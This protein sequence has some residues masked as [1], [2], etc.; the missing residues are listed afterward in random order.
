MEGDE[1]KCV[2][3]WKSVG[4]GKGRCGGG[5]GNVEG[6]GEK[7][8]EDPT[9]PTSPLTSPTLQH[10]SPNLSPHLFSHLPPHFSTPTPPLPHSFHIPPI[11]DPTHQTT[12]N[13]P[14]T[15]PFILLQILYNPL[16]FLILLPHR[17]TIVTL[18]FTPHQNFSLF[19][20]I[21]KLIQQSNTL[22]TPCKFHKKKI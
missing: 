4:E 13:F 22:E 20:V 9:S 19:S 2:G 12:K 10:T 7:W 14:I 8:V 17:T 6:G 21:V 18:S 16:F 3:V 1:E 5:E 11:L 15:P